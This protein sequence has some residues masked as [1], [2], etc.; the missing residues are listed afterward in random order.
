MSA[1]MKWRAKMNICDECGKI[2]DVSNLYV[3]EDAAL[4]LG[5]SRSTIR[6][7]RVEGAKLRAVKRGNG[8]YYAHD[9]LMAFQ[10]LASK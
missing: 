7:W 5:V 6:K 8:Y 2:D 1:D 3:S 10:R 4:V 9:D